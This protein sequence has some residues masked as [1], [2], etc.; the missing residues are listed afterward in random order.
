MTASLPSTR[1]IGLV[2]RIGA[3]KSTVARALAAH[4]AEVIDAD[5]IAH[6]VLDE[7]AV[8]AAVAGL[9]GT[10][11]VRAD[12]S[13][14][15]RALAAVVFGPG[16]AATAGLETLEAIVHPRVRMRIEAALAGP[17]DTAAGDRRIVVLDVPL[18]MQA[19][20][21]D[22]CDRLIL[23]DCDES[24]RRSRLEGR[25]WSDAHRALRDAAWERR[26]RP[27]PAAKTSR[28][29]ASRDAAYI[30]EQIATLWPTL[31]GGD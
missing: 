21:D 5:A 27:P 6:A 11:V 26:Y 14:D 28:V 10:G 3:G 23:V 12:G 30:R 1:V 31:V 16:A 19:G 22:L 17:P 8:R 25:G 4:G 15:R 7:P 29:D 20:W 2:G 24:V 9:F 13:V 18:L